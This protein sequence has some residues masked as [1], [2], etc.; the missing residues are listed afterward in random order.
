MLSTMQFLKEEDQPIIRD[1]DITK[2]ERAISYHSVS[3]WDKWTIL[4]FSCLSPTFLSNLGAW[5]MLI[6]IIQIKELP[7]C[8]THGV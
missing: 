2:V 7:I 4:H 3:A 1:S 8:L 5:S 6:G